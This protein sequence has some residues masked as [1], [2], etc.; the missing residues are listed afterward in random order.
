MIKFENE[1]AETTLI[2]LYMRALES[3]RKDAILKDAHAERI[4]SEIEYDFSKLN[5]KPMSHVGCVVRGKYYDDRTQKFIENNKKPV[6]VNIGC[7]LDTRYQRIKDKRNSVFYELD[8]P[9][10]IDIRRKLIPEEGEDHYIA[11][12]LLETDWL[13][14]LK[15]KHAD[16]QFIF[17]A[18][19]V[20]MYFREEQVKDFLNAIT[21]RFPEGEVCF[22]VCGFMMSKHGVKPD[23]LRDFQA[24]IR[25]GIEDGKEVEKWN[26]NLSLIEQ[27]S[28]MEF[29]RNRWGIIGHTLGRFPRLCR[30][31]S[32]LLCYKII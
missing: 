6:I 14:A 17:I 22:D 23:S 28:Y 31:F 29:F 1:I 10:L 18:E 3:K 9:E 21:D 4:I 8:L 5:N 27:R 26:M 2:P 15:E 12:S 13:D 32:S 7:G 20:L 25:S 11:G 30:K 16:S 19:G 24:E